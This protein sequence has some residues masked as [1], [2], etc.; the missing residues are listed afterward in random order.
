M[1]RLLKKFETA[2][3]LVPQA[4]LTP[5][6]EPARFGVIYYGSTA[7]SMH[8]ALE[9]EMACEPFMIGNVVP[10]G[11]K[12]Q[13]RAAEL[14]NPLD[15][16]P[17]ESGRVDEDVAPI[18]RLANDQVAPGAEA[19]A[20]SKAV[21]ID[22][23]GR[24]RW[25]DRFFASRP[26]APIEAVGRINARVQHRAHRSLRVDAD[27]DYRRDRERRPGRSGPQKSNPGVIDKKVPECSAEPP[28]KSATRQH[29]VP[30]SGKRGKQTVPASDIPAHWKCAGG[31]TGASKVL[32][33][34][35]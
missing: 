16:W 22:I 29:G 1:Q 12:H 11:Q 2:K 25:L 35:N 7:P 31:R 23:L 30:V 32:Q 24:R 15:Q 28:D 9:T 5:S 18:C 17:G 14:L 20:G 27:A 4:V 6:K 8:D 3:K 13:S 34:R 19:R 33:L 26:G 21:E 10:V